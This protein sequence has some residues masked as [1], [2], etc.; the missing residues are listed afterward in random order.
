MA[1]GT[2]VRPPL[3]ECTLR[4]LIAGGDNWG[5]RGPRA[6]RLNSDLP[7]G[8]SRAGD[9]G[10]WM[11]YSACRRTWRATGLR[12]ENGSDA[13]ASRK[14]W[15]K[16]TNAVLLPYYVIP[17][18]HLRRRRPAA[19]PGAHS[20]GCTFPLAPASPCVRY[21]P[22]SSNAIP[23]RAPLPSCCSASRGED[24]RAACRRGVSGPTDRTCR[25][26]SG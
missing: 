23:K 12:K 15:S 17:W 6:D 10:G 14:N 4:P 26:L 11:P 18:A 24:A 13:S 20:L 8:Q 22:C 1:L 19:P 5:G 2:V 16:L 9:L 3:M 21:A 25:V 7:S